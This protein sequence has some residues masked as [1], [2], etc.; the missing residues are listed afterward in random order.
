[1]LHLFSWVLILA[2]KGVSTCRNSTTLGSV[3]P[4]AHARPPASFTAS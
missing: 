4:I 1:V 2:G 3:N